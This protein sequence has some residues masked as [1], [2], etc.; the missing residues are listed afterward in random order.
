M[1]HHTIIVKYPL[2]RDFVLL[3]DSELPNDKLLES[4]F[5]GFNG[6]SQE[7]WPIFLESRLRSLSVHDF[8]FVNNQW[9][10][11][12]SVGWQPVT[13]DYVADIE[14]QVKEHKQFDNF[15]AWFCLNDVM[16]NVK[17]TIAK[18]IHPQQA[19]EV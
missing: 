7:E 1:P 5:A 8:V 3:H 11:C 19:I 18:A 2:Q 9:Y 4:I 15:N 12:A 17:K 6:G 16:F 14:K 10:Q 13:A